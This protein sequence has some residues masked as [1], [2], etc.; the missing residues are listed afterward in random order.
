MDYF[1]IAWVKKEEFFYYQQ[2]DIRRLNEGQW[3]QP[4]CSKPAGGTDVLIVF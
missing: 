4:G 1:Q 3:V 2:G